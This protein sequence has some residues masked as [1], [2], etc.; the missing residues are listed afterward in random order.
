[1]LI[2]WR[3]STAELK[4]LRPSTTSPTPATPPAARFDNLERVR[5]TDGTSSG[6][7]GFPNYR[8][9]LGATVHHVV[10]ERFGLEERV[11]ITNP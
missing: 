7:D 6:D 8:A 1:M 2:V 9:G 10:I 4:R 3:I 11:G 5:S